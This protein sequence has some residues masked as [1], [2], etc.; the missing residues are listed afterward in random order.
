MKTLTPTALTGANNL[1]FRLPAFLFLFALLLQNTAFAQISTNGLI[2]YWNL[3]ETSGLVAHDSSTNGN[4]GNLV[5]TNWPG[6]AGCTLPANSQWITG[7]YTNGALHM[8]PGFTSSTPAPT[9]VEI[10]TITAASMWASSPATTNS[11]TWALWVRLGANNV[12]F[13]NLIGEPTGAGA[14]NNLGFDTTGYIPRILWNNG[15][16]GAATIQSAAGAIPTNVWTHLA[17]TYDNQNQSNLTLYVNGS[18]Q[19]N[20]TLATVRPFLGTVE[21]G[22]RGNYEFGFQGDVD[23]VYVYNRALAP[24]EVAALAGVPFGP[25]QIITPVQNVM[26]W[27]GQ[28]AS[29]SVTASGVGT[30]GYQWYNNNLP[31]TGQTNAQIVIDASAQPSDDGVYTIIITN[32]LGAVTSS[33]S[34]FVRPTVVIPASTP[35]WIPTNGLVFY[36]NM[37]N[38]TNFEALDYSGNNYHGALVNFPFNTS[39][40]VPGFIGNS[41]YIHSTNGS[42]PQV[43]VTN[44][45]MITNLTW[46]CW[47][48]IVP[49]G[50]ACAM[51][52]SFPGAADGSSLGFGGTTN[53][54]HPR[55]LWNHGAA[56]TTLQ[57][58]A[59]VDYNDW[60]QI[61]CTYSQSNTLMTLYLNGEPIGVNDNC[62]ST[63][64]N[65]MA[66]G[67]R[68]AQQAE[69]LNGDIDEVLC[70]NRA[71]APSEMQALYQN[72]LTNGQ[73]PF[74]YIQVSLGNLTISTNY[75]APY[76]LTG[77]F[78]N[79]PTNGFYEATIRTLWTNGTAVLLGT[80][81]LSKPWQVLSGA[82]YGLG[83]T[84][85]QIGTIPTTNSL[86][87]LNPTTLF[88]RASVTQPAPLFSD[89]FQS[90]APGWTHGGTSDSWALGVPTNGPSGGPNGG[91]NGETNVYCTGLNTV[92]NGAEAAWLHSPPINLGGLQQATIVYWEWADFYPDTLFDYGQV[93]LVDATTLQPVASDLWQVSDTTTNYTPSGWVQ[94]VIDIPA[95]NLMSSTNVEIEFMMNTD[96]YNPAHPGWFLDNVEVLPYGNPY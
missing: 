80:T 24:S 72:S 46:S 11:Q 20:A 63:P 65:W 68:L 81:N 71:L 18:V 1:V 57:G 12:G 27:Q 6:D 70:Y 75:G 4:N 94:R 84:P 34:L 47:V 59:G 37:D 88:I 16:T 50:D 41:L 39:Q 83:N 69:S 90:G 15:G 28:P 48:K 8:T 62:T 79:V 85:E 89:N 42:L 87:N 33:A 30:L 91:Y 49:S 31:I 38:T 55:I 21:L 14:G 35:S 76:G 61:G 2:L 3:N 9:R 52:S 78:V 67:I 13:Q 93:N 22:T 36:W 44:L 10:T 58:P 74:R 86:N 53:D 73:T 95:P 19:A 26:V 56:S 25:P 17:L 29:M 5:G 92:Y 60:N 51:S 66:V 40:Q 43:V 64:F 32:Y 54:T 23:E 96:P 7:G 45:P 82:Q 77:H